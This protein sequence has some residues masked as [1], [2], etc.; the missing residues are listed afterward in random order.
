[1]TLLRCSYKINA[2]LFYSLVYSVFLYT[3][4]NRILHLILCSII[5]IDSQQVI[6]LWAIWW[7]YKI[8]FMMNLYFI[9]YNLQLP[10]YLLKTNLQCIPFTSFLILFIMFLTYNTKCNG[11]TI[12]SGLF[13]QGNNYLIQAIAEN[14][15][16]IK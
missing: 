13:N 6:L 14:C 9:T 4:Y 11:N 2:E 8:K 3:R 16:D 12:H 7:W 10:F 15:Y 1:M 5:P